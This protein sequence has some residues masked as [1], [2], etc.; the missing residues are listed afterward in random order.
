MRNV[1]ATGDDFDIVNRIGYILKLGGSSA[2]GAVGW[3][4]R[5]RVDNDCPQRNVREAR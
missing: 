1:F 3:F 5:L 2:G 4:W